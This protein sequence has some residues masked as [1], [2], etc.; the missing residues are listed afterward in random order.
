[1]NIKKILLLFNLI[2]VIFLSDNLNNCL[3]AESITLDLEEAVKLAILNSP[4]IKMADEDVVK[5][6]NDLKLAKKQYLPRLSFQGSAGVDLLSLEDFS[7]NNI[8]TDLILDWNFFQNG[9]LIYGIKRAKVNVV[10]SKL[11]RRDV[12]LELVF[13][14]KTMLYGLQSR[15]EDLEL[16]RQ[17]LEHEK[18]KFEL[19]KVEQE[20]G[21]HTRTDIMRKQASLFRAEN[22]LKSAQRAIDSSKQKL[23]QKIE[24]DFDG[25]TIG[26][27]NQ[28]IKEETFMPLSSEK[29]ALKTAME[30]RND[31]KTTNLQWELS[32]L[33]LKV[34]KWKRWPQIEMFAGSAFAI[35]DLERQSNDLKFR[36]GVIVRYPLYDGGQTKSHIDAAR[37]QER[38]AAL[39]VENIKKRIS[40]DVQDALFSLEGAVASFESSKLQLKILSDEMEKAEVEYKDGRVSQFEWNEAK[41][42]YQRVVFQVKKAWRSVLEAQDYLSKMQGLSTVDIDKGEEQ[43]ENSI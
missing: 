22:E 31:L 35:D 18:A 33:G 21:K 26:D 38:K 10:S 25:I 37:I 23:V 14:I 41:L 30:N 9:M 27:N 24:I 29:E 20:H 39:N 40:N 43:G 12:E 5:S 13:S 7:E 28:D 42:N 11:K 6:E 19:M 34:S 1:M 36:T 15:I 2:L 8:G 32:K 4:E 17:N 3:K 16:A